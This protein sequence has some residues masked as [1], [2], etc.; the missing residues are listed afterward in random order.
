MSAFQIKKWKANW[1]Q[2]ALARD[3]GHTFFSFFKKSFYINSVLS[4]LREV[5]T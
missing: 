4:S 3:L 2:R 1:H 5:I